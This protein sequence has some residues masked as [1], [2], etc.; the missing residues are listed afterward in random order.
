MLEIP[1]PQRSW[2]RRR[3]DPA[4]V[5]RVCD[6]APHQTDR[7]IADV[8]NAEGFTAGGGGAFTWAKVQWLRWKY[9]LPR[10][11]VKRR[12]AGRRSPWGWAIFRASNSGAIKCRRWD[13]R[14]LVYDGGVG[15]SSGGTALP[16]LDHPHAR[17][18][19]RAAQAHP[20]TQATALLKLA[21]RAYTGRQTNWARPKRT[22]PNVFVRGA[23]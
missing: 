21:M 3:T 1:R 4:V 13:S 6:L 8:L 9:K 7:E 17:D 16:A 10:G 14:Q 20:T 12:L 15:V 11:A 2:E 18:Y 22:F 19:R 23:V 5:T